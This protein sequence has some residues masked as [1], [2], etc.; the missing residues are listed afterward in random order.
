MV[1]PFEYYPCF[2][3][4]HL[5]FGFKDAFCA[6]EIVHGFPSKCCSNSHIAL[7]STGSL[8]SSC[9]F[10]F[11]DEKG[12]GIDHLKSEVFQD[13]NKWKSELLME[14]LDYRFGIPLP[15]R[16]FFYGEDIFNPISVVPRLLLSTASR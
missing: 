13:A 4:Y 6:T 5:S 16:S 10:F 1:I 14:E 9:I 3:K 15:A 8:C 2:T 11:V 7:L 12:G